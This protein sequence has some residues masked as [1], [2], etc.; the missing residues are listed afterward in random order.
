[1]TTIRDQK[2]D[3]AVVPGAPAANRSSSNA[4]RRHLISI[5]DLGREG[6]AEVLRVA[7]AFAEVER[8]T[9]PKVPTLR[10]RAIAT[11]FFELS[12]IHI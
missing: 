6:I 4:A 2:L 11:L 10:G 9:I 1:M 3:H 8:R 7:E 5:A 12:L